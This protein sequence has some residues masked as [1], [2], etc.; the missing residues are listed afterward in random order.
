LD[1]VLARIPRWASE[2]VLVGFDTADDAGVYKLTPE[3]ALVQTVDFFTPIVDDPYTFGAI[4]AANALSDVYAMGGKPISAL[5][6]LGWPAEGDLDDLAEILR[7]GAEKIHE[8]DCVLLGGH[9]IKDPEVKFGYAVTG[10]IHPDRIKTNAGAR[11]GDALL[12]T[13]RIGTGVISTALKQGIAKESDVEAAVQSMLKLNR[14][15]CEAMLEFDVHGCTDVTGFGLIGH[16]REMAVASK[17]TLEI[18]ARAVRFLP[19]AADYARQGAI[20]GGLKNNREFAAS[21]VEGSSDFDDLLYDPQTS[22]GLLIALPERDAEA[23]QTKLP[24][25]YRI[26][27]VTER[28]AKPIRLTS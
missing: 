24:D 25:A 18:D 16:A 12:F 4:A 2:N 6:I 19:G 8:A 11:P 7:G 10:T 20:P 5:S 13:K 9:S 21:C 23:L 17:V 22:G 27:Q 3:C 15:A 28:Q 26:G 14:A 1:Q